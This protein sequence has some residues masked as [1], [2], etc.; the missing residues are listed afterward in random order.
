VPTFRGAAACG[1][2]SG[3][4]VASPQGFSA[5]PLAVWRFYEQ[6]RR[7]LA[8]VKPNPAHHVLAA[9]QGRFAS[10]RLVTQ[11]VDGLHQA[12]GARDVLELHGSIWTV[13]CLGC[14]QE[15]EERRVPLPELRRCAQG[16]AQ[17]SGPASCGSGS[18]SRV[19]W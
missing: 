12:A 13:R 18:S 9:W 7:N 4:G 3:G 14:G 8:S 10:Y 15:R 17:W 6:R 1:G 16:V 5:D 2:P 19:T 11:N